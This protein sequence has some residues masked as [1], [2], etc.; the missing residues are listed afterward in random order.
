MVDKLRRLFVSINNVYSIYLSYI[1]STKFVL[2]V[3]MMYYYIE[4]V[5]ICFSVKK[6]PKEE[7]DG[8]TVDSEETTRKVNISFYLPVIQSRCVLHVIF[9]F[10]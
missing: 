9:L 10:V 4:N 1:S 8:D 2:Y 6:E 5:R 7:T 3:V